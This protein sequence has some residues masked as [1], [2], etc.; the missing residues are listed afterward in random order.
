M[1]NNFL[2]YILNYSDISTKSMNNFYVILLQFSGII[3]T[4]YVIKAFF[5]S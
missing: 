2:I 5:L 1:K 4:L 3:Y